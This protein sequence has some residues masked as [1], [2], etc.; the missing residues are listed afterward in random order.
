MTAT[1]NREWF[2][3]SSVEGRQVYRVTLATQRLS[4]YSLKPEFVATDAMPSSV[5]VD[6]FAYS[7]D[8][9]NNAHL[10]GL[11]EPTYE[12]V[13]EKAEP[14]E[15]ELEIIATVD[16]ELVQKAMNFPVYGTYSHEGKRW[17]VTE[18]SI[19]VSLLDRIT[20]PSLLHQEVPCQLSSEDSF[21]I[22]RTHVKDNID[23]KVAAITSDYDFC[24]TVQ[25]KI[26]LAEPEPYTRDANF[27]F[28][29]RR[30]K[31]RMVTDY[32]TER[33]L[34]VYETAPLRGGEVYKGYTKTE[35]FTGHNVQELKQNIEAYL[36]E[37]M[38][39]INKPLV[40]CP[41]CKGHGVMTA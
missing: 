35:P 23:P 17:S 12:P 16:G 8:K 31:P 19:Q 15:I 33:K 41:N 38:A 3:V 9:Q 2:K 11:Y 22:I 5:G 10:R 30:R 39:E 13:P 25:K 20:A 21:K 24:L 7:D 26:K 1:W 40:D 32:R 14:I 34:V 28:F 37:L 6:F 29:G 27:S 18:Q 4:G 36:K